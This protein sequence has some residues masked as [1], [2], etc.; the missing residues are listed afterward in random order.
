[1]LAEICE[2]IGANWHEIV[3]ALRLDQRIGQFS[4]IEAGLGISGGN[5][6]RDLAT[7][8]S[9]AKKIGSSARIASAWEENSLHRKQWPWTQIKDLPI[10]EKSDIVI[11]ILGLSYKEGTHSIK[12][13]PAIKLLQNLNSRIVKA[14]DP[15]VKTLDDFNVLIQGNSTDVCS[16]A[17]ILVFMTSCEEFRNMDLRQIKRIMRGNVL[18][19]PFN[20]FDE[21]LAFQLG[22]EHKIIGANSILSDTN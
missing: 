5:L 20:I 11:G 12:N 21:Q 22:F 4:Y 8:K 10:M 14:Y 7:V 15:I 13:S 18:I 3:P 6:E 17:D 2:G 1:M 16:G 9:L 19:D